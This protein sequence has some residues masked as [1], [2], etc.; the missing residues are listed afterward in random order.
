[1]TELSIKVK[2]QRY[3]EA[4]EMAKKEL[5]ACGTQDCDA[6]KQVFRLFPE[7]KESEDKRIKK[8]IIDTLKNYHHLIST[9]GV[10]KEDMLAWLEKQGENVSLPKFT[11]D[12]VLALQC[13]M[14]TTKKIQ[15]DKELYEQLQS[16]HDR[17]HDAYWLKKEGEQNLTDKVEPKFKVGDI[18]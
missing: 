16:L 13:C 5:Q 2:A 10:T 11:F 7:L 14:E 8:C 9:G 3:N 12:D 4:I 6:A 15:E 1:M 18:V 17:L